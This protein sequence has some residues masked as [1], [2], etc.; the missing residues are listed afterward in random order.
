MQNYVDDPSVYQG[1][2]QS[3]D[4]VE[5]QM[6]QM[7]MAINE[8]NGNYS[9]STSFAAAFISVNPITAEEGNINIAGLSLVD[10]GILD[11]QG[12]IKV[13]IDN[14]SAYNLQINNITISTQNGGY[15][16]F[17]KGQISS[18]TGTTGVSGTGSIT[19]A[20]ASGAPSVTI[21]NEDYQQNAGNPTSANNPPTPEIDVV[22]NITDVNGPVTIK[23][24]GNIN[25]MGGI[26]AS[27]LSA[28]PAQTAIS[29]RVT[30]TL[31]TMREGILLARGRQ[32]RST[33]RAIL[34]RRAQP[35]GGVTI[36]RMRAAA[37][38]NR[39]F[40]LLRSLRNTPPTQSKVLFRPTP[41]STS[42]RIAT[43]PERPS[44]LTRRGF[45]E[46]AASP[47]SR[48]EQPIT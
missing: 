3:L 19:A 4:Y 33:P 41:S 28:S 44:S 37:R 45:L 42:G 40:P 8:G 43:P 10:N 21:T 26:D 24:V 48:T 27:S 7:G 47:A 5:S 36:T 17:N 34:R 23:A 39:P 12:D 20:G 38:S 22:G 18:L 14:Q 9:Y 13:N 32:S 6:Q 2:Q 1:Y 29:S 11:A 15:V 35:T 16:T 30:P 46:A 25:V 31:L